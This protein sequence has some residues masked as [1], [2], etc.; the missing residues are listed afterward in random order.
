MAS[1]LLV[2]LLAYWKL[3]TDSWLD[4]TGNGYTLV[5]AGSTPAITGI[6]IINDGTISSNA[7]WLSNS[8]ITVGSSYSVSLWVNP[9][10][11]SGDPDCVWN[12]GGFSGPAGVVANDTYFFLGDI[13]G[14]D[15]NLPASPQCTIGDWINICYVVDNTAQEQYFYINGVLQT[16]GTYA[17]DWGEWTSFI[18][19]AFPNRSLYSNDHLDEVGIWNRAITQSEVTELY[20][21]GYGSSYPF[22]PNPSYQTLYYNNAEADGD[23]GNILNWWQDV[24]F[25][26]PATALPTV[27]NAINLYSE[28]TQNT[29]GVNQCFCKSAN[30]WSANFGAGLILESTGVVNMQGSSILAGTILDGVSM[31]DSSTIAI[32]GEVLGDL[33]LRDGSTN[34]GLVQGNATVYSD[35]GSGTYPIGGTV[36]GTV[37]YIGFNLGQTCYFN[38]AVNTLLAEVGNWW[39]DSAYTIPAGFVPDNTNDVVFGNGISIEGITGAASESTTYNSIIADGSGFS[40][41]NYNFFTVI[42]TNGITATNSVFF[43]CEIDANGSYTECIFSSTDYG[44]ATIGGNVNL[45]SCVGII[46]N[47]S[48]INVSLFTGNVDAYYP[49]YIASGNVQGTLT[50]HGYYLYNTCIAHCNLNETSGTRTVLDLYEE[51]FISGLVLSG[52]GVI[53]VDGTYT[54]ISGGYTTFTGPNGNSVVWN[55]DPDVLLWQLGDVTVYYQSADLSTWTSTNALYDPPPV[56]DN[57]L[58]TPI[59]VGYGTGLIGNAA[60]FNNNSL[61]NPEPGTVTPFSFLQVQFSIS[62]WVNFPV[63]PSTPPQAIVGTGYAFYPNSLT[64]NV[65]NSN[66]GLFVDATSGGQITGPSVTANTW[67]NCVVTCTTNAIKFYVDGVFQAQYTTPVFNT[68][69]ICLSQYLGGYQLTNNALVDELN[70]FNIDLNQEEINTL[71]NNGAGSTFPFVNYGTGYGNIDWARMLHLPFFFDS[72]KPSLARLLYLP[73]FINI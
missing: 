6:G 73:W 48:D 46:T 34:Q 60:K 57:Q 29:Q 14:G 39:Q 41:A 20:Q 71:Y 32:T 63:V 10:S 26:Q 55:S 68:A 13:G 42:A 23:W 25:T 35:G 11:F 59:T 1:T 67:H 54:R 7:T 62:V 16:T 70:T 28:V 66:L 44:G 47:D 69:G 51:T 5:D 4:S 24:G 61:V 36:V 43:S 50:R 3:D 40:G 33:V 64:I 22:I 15:T 38:N 52:S 37:T 8:S 65:E 56:T 19:G 27:T 17:G 31:H 58:T 9:I 45:Y 53:G 12:L 49:T 18:L 30:F 21:N 72:R 2:D